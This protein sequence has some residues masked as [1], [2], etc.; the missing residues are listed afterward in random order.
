MSDFFILLFNVQ[1]QVFGEEVCN[2]EFFQSNLSTST[3][4]GTQKVWPLLTGCLWFK[5]IKI[6]VVVGSGSYFESGQ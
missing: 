3:T 5:K 4:L 1:G 2:Q 6:V